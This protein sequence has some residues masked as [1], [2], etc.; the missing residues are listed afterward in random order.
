MQRFALVLAL[1]AL[2][3][4]AQAFDCAKA[5][6]RSEKA[7]CGDA[8][9]HD[10]DLAMSKAFS[11]LITGADAKFRAAALSAQIAWIKDRDRLCSDAKAGELA[12]CLTRESDS[13]RAFLSGEPQQGPGA[14]SRI[15]PWFRVEKGGHGKAEVDMELLKF[16]DPKSPGE[17]AF[18][19]ATG[20][21]L[22]DIAEPE[23]DDPAA[24]HYAFDNRMTLVYASPKLVSAQASAYTDSGGA[25][26][27]SYVANIN[28]DVAA[29]RLLTFADAF[30]AKAA[31]KIFARCEEQVKGQKKERMGGDAPLAPDDLKELAKNVADSTGD[32]SNWS[33]GANKVEIVYNPYAVGSYAE[34]AYG[35]DLG[36][37]V[38]RP[39]VKPGFPL[40]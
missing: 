30:D 28:L 37:D 6:S 20:K 31:Q 13:R 22:E 14:P 2:G 1:C 5:T 8:R 19:A 32:L 26:P 23:K 10:A 33:F 25:H 18:N 24:D 38:L 4:Q 17:R 3:S 29:D 27:N 40:P 16:T 35:C 7:I 15:A 12:A 9:A 34:G 11:D 39:L 21:F 36:Y